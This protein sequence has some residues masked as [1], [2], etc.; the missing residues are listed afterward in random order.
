M[1]CPALVATDC[2][3]GRPAAA[4]C[5]SSQ[6]A[7]AWGD[8]SWDYYQ[9]ERMSAEFKQQQDRA[10]QVETDRGSKFKL[11]S[12]EAQLLQYHAILF[13]RQEEM[14]DLTQRNEVAPSTCSAQPS[15]SSVFRPPP[16]VASLCQQSYCQ[17]GCWSAALVAQRPRAHFAAHNSEQQARLDCLRS[18][19]NHTESPV[20]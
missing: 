5:S 20:L 8:Q 9:F 12:A 16:L 18:G 19:L 10:R 13:K 11:K 4:S 17:V 14:N 6:P 1:S 7:Q 15:S 2:E 3:L